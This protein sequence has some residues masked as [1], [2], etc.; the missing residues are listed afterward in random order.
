MRLIRLTLL[1]HKQQMTKLNPKSVVDDSGKR[2][3]VQLDIDAYEELLEELG[4]A[5][6]GRAMEVTLR[7]DSER[8]P[9]VDAKALFE[10][11]VADQAKGR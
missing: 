4:D 7:E 1:S 6:L 2:V 8:I 5:A 11:M 9:V 3:A 10:Q